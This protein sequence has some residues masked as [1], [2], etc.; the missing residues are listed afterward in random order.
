MNSL[1]EQ[2]KNSARLKEIISVLTKYGIADWL[3]DTKSEKIK[4]YLKGAVG[5][6]VLNK[7]KEEHIRLALI[8]LGTTFIKFGQILSTRSDIIGSKLANELAKLQT[9]TPRDSIALVRARIKKE[10]GIKSL[11]EIFVEF[12]TKP[13]ASASIAQVHKATLLSGEVVAVK[14]MRHDIEEKIIEDLDI[15]TYLAGIAQRHGGQLKNYQPLQLIRQFSQVMLNELDFRLELKN[16]NLFINDFEN[17][18]R[19]VFPIAYKEYSSKKVL[20]MS[21][22]EGYSL[23]DINQMDWTQE[24]KSY[25]TEESADVF[26]EMMFRDRFYHADPHPGN[27]LVRKDGSIGIIDCGMVGRLDQ[28]TNEVFEELI[29]GVAQKDGE[30]IK[31]V[32]LNMGVLPKGVEYDLLTQQIDGFIAKYLDLPLKDFDMSAAIGEMTSIIQQHNII[33]PPNAAGLLRT[34]GLLEGSFRLLNSDF[35]L[36]IL[37]KKYHYKILIRRYSPKSLLTRIFKNIHQWENVIELAPKAI[38]KFLHQAGKD[39]FEVNLEHRNLEKS[40]NRVVLGMLSSAIFL[41]SSMLWSFQVPPL[42]NGYSFVGIA[43]I[44]VSIYLGYKLIKDINKKQGN[45]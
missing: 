12:D 29:I 31:N 14:V 19:V 26:M 13:I 28:K 21:F 33:L 41:G 39:N 27:L 16:I 10:L 30:H 5:K 4:K 17:D 35:N 43:G 40:V 8:E 18:D 32:I 25:F 44:L 22:L 2:S 42:I 6:D 9:S 15:L 11:D 45:G 20:T 34:V 3:K 23:Q 36:A 37:F 7:T 38:S 1:T 24:Q